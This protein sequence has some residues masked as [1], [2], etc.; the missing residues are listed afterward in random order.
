MSIAAS[1]DIRLVSEDWG[2]YVDNR[3]HFQPTPERLSSGY[4]T[5]VSNGVKSY[6]S[7]VLSWTVVLQY[8]TRTLRQ[9]FS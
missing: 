4:Q 8:C 6:V 3:R 1:A 5:V 2:K 9:L 7:S